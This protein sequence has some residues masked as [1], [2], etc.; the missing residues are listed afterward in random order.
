MIRTLSSG[1]S[2]G[3]TLIELMATIA[4]AA[5]LIAIGVPSYQQFV[6]GQR[7]RA[8]VSA[9]NYTLLFARSEAIKRNADVVV[10]PAGN[11]WQGGWTVSVGG[12]TLASEGGY[13]DLMIAARSS[14]APSLSFNAEGRIEGNTTPFEVSSR[15][16]TDVAKRCVSVDLSGLPATQH[17]VCRT[18][19]ASC[20]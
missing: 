20:S 11:C 1:R 19:V 7:V 3:F 16:A 15:S 18:A 8:A 9:L 2:R 5:I 14:P 4:V 12:S 13:P 17:A 6:A 10:A